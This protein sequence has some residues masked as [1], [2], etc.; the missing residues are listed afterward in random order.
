MTSQ[1]A[2]IAAGT[3]NSRMYRQ[4][5]GWIVSR[6]DDSVKAWRTTQEKPYAL[7]RQHLA[8]N[9]VGDAL[10]ALGYDPADADSLA[11]EVT[12]GTVRDRVSRIVSGARA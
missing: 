12:G 8:D 11:M 5:D 7:A 9:R 6:Y 1:T 10:V 2:A 3:A 4:G